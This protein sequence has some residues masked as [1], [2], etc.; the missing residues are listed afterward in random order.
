MTGEIHTMELIKEFKK[1]IKLL[2]I[3]LLVII[4]GRMILNFF[5]IT[6]TI[7]TNQAILKY[8]HEY[9]KIDFVVDLT[10]E[11]SKTIKKILNYKIQT[12]D[13]PACGFNQDIAIEFGK[14]SFSPACDGCGIVK[15]GNTGKYIGISKKNKDKIV[16]IYEKYGGVWPCV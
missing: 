1:S 7:K 15:V 13:N 12:K 14:M 4:G 11:E 2:L 6:T 8:K 10:P 5:P 9:R 3:I 16:A